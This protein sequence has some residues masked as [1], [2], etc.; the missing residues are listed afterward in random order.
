MGTFRDVDI[1]PISSLIFS[2]DPL[3]RYQYAR[4]YEAKTGQY[5]PEALGKLMLAVLEDG[6]AC[7]Q[8]YFFKP[9]RKNEKLFREAEEWIASDSDDPFSFSDILRNGCCSP[10]HLRNQTKVSALRYMFEQ[11]QDVISKL[12]RLLPHFQLLERK[13]IPLSRFALSF[14]SN[15][16]P[17]YLQLLT[18]SLPLSNL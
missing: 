5:K 1:D 10:L 12:D 18:S 6:I 13:D 15:L 17:S 11:S 14:S 16:L 4:L 7:F 8:T 3:L 2:P 9:S